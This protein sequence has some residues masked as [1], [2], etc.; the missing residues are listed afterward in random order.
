[1]ILIDFLNDVCSDKD[2]SSDCA[3]LLRIGIIACFGSYVYFIRILLIGD[4]DIDEISVP[5]GPYSFVLHVVNFEHILFFQEDFD[6]DQLKI[7]FLERFFLFQ[8]LDYLVHGKLADVDA[9][10][11]NS[12]SDG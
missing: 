12:M 5:D 4:C 8:E 6:L 9:F 10:C 7:H 11:S 2:L 3:L 1:M